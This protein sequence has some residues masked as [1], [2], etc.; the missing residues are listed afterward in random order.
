MDNFA[1]TIA[2]GCCHRKRVPVAYAFKVGVIFTL[3]HFIM[4][5]AGWLFGAGAGRLLNTVD[6]W[7]AF[8]ILAFIGGRMIKESRSDKADSDVC[9]LHS[10]KTLFVLAVATSLD[11]LLVGMGMAFTSASFWQLVWML[12]ACVMVTSVMGFY[13]GAWLGRKF[14]KVMEA[15]GGVVLML[16]GVKL[17]LE[18]LGIW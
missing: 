12:A 9:I 6:H 13:V 18:G 16:I 8:F 17:L 1:V 10:L 15:A 7:I 3:A 2:S 5:S 14:G 11:A 4:F